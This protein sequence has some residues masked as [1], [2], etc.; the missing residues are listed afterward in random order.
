MQYLRGLKEGFYCHEILFEGY[1]QTY[2]IF[3]NYVE[4][5]FFLLF[6]I[7]FIPVDFI[8]FQL[9]YST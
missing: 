2:F 4:I 1:L 7:H 8:A 3:I 5:I 6:Y 9:F